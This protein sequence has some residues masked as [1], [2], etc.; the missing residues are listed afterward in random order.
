MLSQ[1]FRRVG[2]RHCEASARLFATWPKRR[3]SHDI[4]GSAHPWPAH[5]LQNQFRK[6]INTSASR[7]ES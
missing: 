5:K 7:T 2:S 6:P 3:Q 1:H 4:P